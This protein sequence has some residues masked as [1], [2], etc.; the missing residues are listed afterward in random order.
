[1]KII[2]EE[3]SESRKLLPKEVIVLKK[4]FHEGRIHDC[5]GDG[6]LWEDCINSAG[7]IVL[8]QDGYEDVIKA[9]AKR[10]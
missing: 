5:V 6:L 9:L 1:M 7:N 4:A 10:R 8:D 3:N 2:D